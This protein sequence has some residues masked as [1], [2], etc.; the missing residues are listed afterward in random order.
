MI[1]NRRSGAALAKFNNRGGPA[2][3]IFGSFCCV[4]QCSGSAVLVQRSRDS[5]IAHG[6]PLATTGEILSA[7]SVF[8]ISM[9][10]TFDPASAR[11]TLFSGL[12]AAA[13]RFGSDEPILEDAD[14]NKLTYARLILASLVLGRRLK[15][16]TRAG[17][18]VGLLLPN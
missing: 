15:K 12:V 14:G 13:Q 18:Y 7:P 17:D 4:A 6:D 3:G 2:A 8:A 5:A 9:T 10:Q 1:Q 11:T 16:V